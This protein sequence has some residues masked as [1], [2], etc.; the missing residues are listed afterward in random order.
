MLNDGLPKPNKVVQPGDAKYAD[1][2]DDNVIDD[3]D[4]KYDGFPNRPEYVLGSNWKFGWKGFNLTLNWVG[5]TNVSRKLFSDYCVPFTNSSHGRGLLQYFADNCWIDNDNPWAPG[6]ED[7]TLPRFTNNNY[8]WNSYLSSLTV[9]DASY[10]RLKSASFGY[11]FTK[12][13]LI[14]KLGIGSV[15]LMFTGYNILTF[16]KMTLQDPEAKSS[17]SDGTYPLVK[18]YNLALNINF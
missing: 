11:T 7:G 12:G 1:I 15:G 10:L 5:A 18:T 8:E 13:R 6:R 4:K 16:S 3:N 14:D 17:D 2:N 9:Q